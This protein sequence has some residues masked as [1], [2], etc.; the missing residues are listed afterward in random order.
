[1]FVPDWR[2]SRLHGILPDIIPTLVPFRFVSHPTVKPLALPKRALAAKRSVDLPGGHP[3][4]MGHHGVQIEC[5]PVM[6]CDQRVPVI[7]HDRLVR[8]DDALRAQLLETMVQCASR[9][10]CGQGTS[11]HAFMQKFFHR[12]KVLALQP[13]EFSG[14][15]LDRLERDINLTQSCNHRGR[16]TI[17]TAHGHKITS[18]FDFPMWQTSPRKARGS[19]R[20]IH[21]QS[22]EGDS[23]CAMS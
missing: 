4:Q 12:Q 10:W 11:T 22:L 16:Q 23:I 7:G 17:G 9:D 13:N 15:R 8:N 20:R 19:G 18:A 1:M 5:A 14:A 6:R 21:A 3:F 2:Q